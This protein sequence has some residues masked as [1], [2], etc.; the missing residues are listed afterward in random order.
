MF[1]PDGTLISASAA[2][3]CGAQKR[4]REEDKDQRRRR[5][6]WLGR[7][8]KK[9][10]EEEDE[11]KAK[12]GGGAGKKQE[13][14]ELVTRYLMPSEPRKT[15]DCQCQTQFIQSQVKVTSMSVPNTSQSCRPVS[16]NTSY[17]ITS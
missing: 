14:E 11:D 1:S 10:E 5:R 7:Q 16:A 4:E 15:Q 17:P 13:D 8:K 12:E 3:H 6:R 2:P 9:K